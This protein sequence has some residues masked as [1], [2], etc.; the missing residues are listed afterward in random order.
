MSNVSK[1]YVKRLAFVCHTSRDSASLRIVNEQNACQTSRLGFESAEG[2]GKEFSY[3]Q[4]SAWKSTVSRRLTC[5]SLKKRMPNVSPRMSNV[6]FKRMSNVSL[7]T[8]SIVL[9]V[10]R[11][12]CMLTH[13]GRRIGAAL[14]RNAWA[15]NPCFRDTCHAD[16]S[17]GRD[18]TFDMRSGGA[19]RK[20]T[21]GG[22]HLP[23]DA[24]GTRPSPDANDAGVCKTGTLS[25]AGCLKFFAGLLNGLA[26]TSDVDVA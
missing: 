22:F 9:H 23:C 14:A 19:G 21:K 10:K 24:A 25:E 5:V 17:S 26:K 4:S 6:S 2:A 13:L 18:E 12:V 7:W 3:P 11:L 15:R 1:A 8:T 16:A 20:N